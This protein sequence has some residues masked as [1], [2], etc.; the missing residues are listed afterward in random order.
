MDKIQALNAQLSSWSVLYVKIHKYHWYVE[1]P[2]FFTLHAK[3]EELYNDATAFTDEIA[4]R[5]LTIG[6]KPLATMKEYLAHSEIEECDGN[7]PAKEMVKH[8]VKDYETII[9][10]S[11][12]LIT[13]CEN[14]DDNETADL[15]R[16]KIS[17]LEKTLWMLKAY[18]G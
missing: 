7:H 14:D 8:L 1:G 3:F 4:E 13:T 9:K 17:E 10:S 18:L 2:E 15:F 12:T 16:G 5:I 6:A 11:R